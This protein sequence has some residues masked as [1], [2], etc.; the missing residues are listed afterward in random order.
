MKAPY[1]KPD[2]EYTEKQLA[3]LE[4]LAGDALGNVKKAML[5]AGYAPLTLPREVLNPLQDEIIAL[6]NSVLTENAVK[7]AFGLTGVLDDPTA[8]GAK[9]AV[10]AATQL[11]DRVGIVKKEK[12][13]V[14][15][16]SGGLFI[17]PPKKFAED[18]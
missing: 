8:L 5:L 18:E 6:A 2:K 14:S 1:L 9:N 3:F 15:S 13:E 17:L 12:L 7:A 4:H 11:L 10:T 16:E